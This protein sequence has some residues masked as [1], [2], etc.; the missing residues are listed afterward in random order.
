MTG[1][2]EYARLRERADAALAGVGDAAQAAQAAADCVRWCREHLPPDDPELAR[3][4]VQH[5]VA[6]SR[7]GETAGTGGRVAYRFESLFEEALALQRTAFGP[8]SEVVAITLALYADCLRPRDPLAAIAPLRERLTLLWNLRGPSHPD[9]GAAACLLA[10]TQA[11]TSR[12]LSREASRQYQTC[13]DVFATQPPHPSAAAAWSGRAELAEAEG[14]LEAADLA[15]RR[16][17]EVTRALTQEPSADLAVRLLGA[18]RVAFRGGDRDSAASWYE[19]ALA[20]Q[21]ALSGDA[22]LDVAATWFS[23]SLSTDGDRALRASREALRSAGAWL[24]TGAAAGLD[25]RRREEVI[26]AFAAYADRHLLSLLT[27]GSGDEEVFTV[28][29]WRMRLPD[30]LSRPWRLRPAPHPAERELNA[31]LARIATRHQERYQR[32]DTDIRVEAA[33]ESYQGHGEELRWLRARRTELEGR[34]RRESLPGRRAEPLAGE[35]LGTARRSLGRED[36]LLTIVRVADAYVALVVGPVEGRTTAVSLGQ[37]AVVDQAVW[38]ARAALEGSGRAAAFRD[39]A[40][41]PVGTDDEDAP[42]VLARLLIEPLLP[43]LAEC[44]RLRVALDGPLLHVPLGVLPLGSAPFLSSYAVDYVTALDDLAAPDRANAVTG[45]DVVLAAPD[46]D[47]G[48]VG[49]ANPDSLFQPLDGTAEEA[50][51]IAGLRPEALVLTGRDAAKARLR[52]L[53]SP[54]VLHLATHGY[55]FAGTPPGDPR[56]M[57]RRLRGN[58]SRLAGR[59]DNLRREPELRSGLALAGANTWLEHGGP[60]PEGETG[61]LTVADVTGLDLAATELVVLSACDTGVGEITAPDGHVS[62]RAAFLRAGARAV[63]ASLWKVPDGPTRDLMISFYRLLDQGHGPA[64]ALRTAQRE[65]HAAGE[66]VL[67]WGA[68]VCYITATGGGDGD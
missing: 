48:G 2:E 14:D 9:V 50:R 59:Y 18:A 39:V 62:L 4:L 22:A 24:L 36:R 38:R 42:A 30:L 32:A 60:G 12:L 7:T 52:E 58:D 20:V 53:R 49:P 46:Y 61:L 51:G 23:I 34:L 1:D 44:R 65:R 3:A 68:F 5:A 15:Y 45:P 55:T 35:L 63:V 54:R 66:P 11:E 37:A 33:G 10:Q 19:E 13:L 16:A 57:N 28:S 43:H 26:H 29:A 67:N 27:I 31:V 47:L 64:E 8:R 21:R 41:C 40:P 25:D 56:D 17:V 6:T